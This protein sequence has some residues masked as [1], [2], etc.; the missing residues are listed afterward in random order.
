MSAMNPAG[1]RVGG[2]G[3]LQAMLAN[4]TSTE[5]GE[6]TPKI[7][8]GFKNAYMS[9]NRTLSAVIWGA[10]DGKPEVRLRPAQKNVAGRGKDCPGE[11]SAPWWI[12]TV[13]LLSLFLV[14]RALYAR[15]YGCYR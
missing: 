8:S 14:S 1:W 15:R 12:M 4:A 6:D 10:M 5:A 2:G 3:A 13:Q 7:H 11:G 9:V